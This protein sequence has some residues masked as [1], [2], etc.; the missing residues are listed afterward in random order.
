MASDLKIVL[1]RICVRDRF[2]KENDV[3]IISSLFL[4]LSERQQFLAFWFLVTDSQGAIS[5][6]CNSIRIDL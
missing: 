2:L 4:S 3:F 6:N 1:F 5:A